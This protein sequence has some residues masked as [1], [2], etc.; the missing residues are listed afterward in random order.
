VFWLFLLHD[1]MFEVEKERKR[2]KKKKE[3]EMGE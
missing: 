3:R 2:E 1:N